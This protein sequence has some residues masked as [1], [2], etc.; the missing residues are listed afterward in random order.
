MKDKLPE[1][2]GDMYM[3]QGIFL[4]TLHLLVDTGVVSEEDAYK[5]YKQCLAKYNMWEK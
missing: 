5:K 4:E 2:S 3:T 1:V